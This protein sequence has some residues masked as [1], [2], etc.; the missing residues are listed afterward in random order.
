[1]DRLSFYSTKLLEVSVEMKQLISRQG[2]EYEIS[3]FLDIIWD[4]TATQHLVKTHWTGFD[5]ADASFEPFSS[6]LDQVPKFLLNF[7]NDLYIK[8][9]AKVQAIFKH[10]RKAIV[11][12]ISMKCRPS[13]S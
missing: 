4:A 2:I 9:P 7:M 5:I 13:I 11:N 10:E 12:A 8:D 1:V 3:E 6:L